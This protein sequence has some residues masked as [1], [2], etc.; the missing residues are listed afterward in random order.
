MK[1]V[2]VN[3]KKNNLVKGISYVL[4][5]IFCMILTK[6]TQQG[7]YVFSLFPCMIAIYCWVTNDKK[8]VDVK[9]A[10]TAITLACILSVYVIY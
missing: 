5:I 7:L 1:N 3:N 4:S 10:S 8:M 6:A 2:K 9:W